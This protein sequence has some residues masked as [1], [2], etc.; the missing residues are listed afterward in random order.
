MLAALSAPS[1]PQLQF[2]VMLGIMVIVVGYIIVA[3]WQQI[4]GGIA[5]IGCLVIL[6]SGD[7]TT[8][9]QSVVQIEPDKKEFMED[10]LAMTDYTKVQCD[11]LWEDRPNDER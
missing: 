9:K 6:C 2:I 1:L 8:Q 10:C 5:V 11:N 4:I 7:G 3:F